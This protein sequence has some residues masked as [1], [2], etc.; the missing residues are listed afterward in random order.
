[1]PE[2][3]FRRARHQAVAAALRAMNAGF[4]AE[5]ECHF[6]GG[7]RIVLEL[8]EYRESEDVG[9][10]CASRDGY[11]MLRSTVRETSL[12]DVLAEPL[13]LAREVRADRY[14]IRTFVAIDDARLKLEIVHEGRI[15]IG[16]EDV[17]G[18]PVPCLD[19][20]SCF[21][22]KYLAN[23]DRGADDAMLARDIVDL[24][25]MIEAWGE[26]TAAK[27]A[28]IAREAYGAVVDTACRTAA[29]RLLDG[30]AL[31]RKFAAALRVT[32]TA[33]LEAGL[34][35]LARTKARRARGSAGSR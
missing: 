11:R 35:R 33:T 7:T 27:G 29:Q 26:S 25:F 8:G 5:A 22:E 2:R 30:P 18:I 13:P 12:G 20:V 31:R 34:K 3:R 9:F 23:A 14:G 32:D 4:L 16:G 17:A 15:A 24:A 6:A 10:L 19:R 1:M 28:A 21:A